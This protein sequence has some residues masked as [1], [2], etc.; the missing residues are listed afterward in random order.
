M[1]NQNQCTYKQAYF[2]PVFITAL[3]AF[4]SQANALIADRKGFYHEIDSGPRWLQ[5]D[6]QDLI[7]SNMGG[8]NP[9]HPGPIGSQGAILIN[10]PHRL[11]WNSQ[12]NIFSTDGNY[13]VNVFYENKVYQCF[14]ESILLADFYGIRL[15][16]TLKQ[17]S[18]AIFDKVTKKCFLKEWKTKIYTF[19]KTLTTVV[20]FAWR[21]VLTGKEIF[22]FVILARPGTLEVEIERASTQGN[23][24]FSVSETVPPTAAPTLATVSVSHS[25]KTVRL[26]DLPQGKYYF[27]LQGT[28]GA[29]FQ[30][31][32]DGESVSEFGPLVAN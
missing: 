4:N 7:L 6:E 20:P 9:F 10:F 12:E 13:I 24:S 8:E 15:D 21:E 22:Y 29:V 19:E 11:N 18:L 28:S 26:K 31:K 14:I 16:I 30:L 17:P 23:L 1:G 2:G 32:L 3:I 25:M 5:V 27:S